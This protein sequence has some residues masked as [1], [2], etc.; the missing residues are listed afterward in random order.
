MVLVYVY[1]RERAHAAHRHL[2]AT[3][4]AL[5]CSA[6]LL[7][8]AVSVVRFGSHIAVPV[9]VVFTRQLNAKRLL[10]VYF[11]DQDIAILNKNL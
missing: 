4:F 1:T 8:I 6:L 9:H 7:A 11:L 2:A 10:F 5:S 3:S